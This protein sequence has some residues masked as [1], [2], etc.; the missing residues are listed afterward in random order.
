MKLVIYTEPIPKARARTVVNNGK[1]HSY[2]P[3]A[4]QEAENTIRE[5]IVRQ[6]SYEE[7]GLMH[8][9]LCPAGSPLKVD[10]RFVILKPPSTP[11][12]RQWP[13]VRPDWDN[14]AKLVMDACNGYLWADDSQVCSCL[15]TKEYGS[16]P[17]IEIEVLPL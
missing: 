6:T 15:T 5:E 14:Y 4:T 10:L 2:T 11:K 13:V 8:G 1:V 3:K 17:R 7:H 12:K 16:P 9:T